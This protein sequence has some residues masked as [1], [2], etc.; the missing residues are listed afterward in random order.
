MYIHYPW[1][2]SGREGGVVDGLLPIPHRKIIDICQTRLSD[3]LVCVC[4]QEMGRED[5]L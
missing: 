3:L 4:F 1:G 2:G 5:I